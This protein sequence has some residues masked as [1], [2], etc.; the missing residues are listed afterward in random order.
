MSGINNKKEVFL[1][2]AKESDTSKWKFYEMPRL[3]DSEALEY[4]VQLKRGKKLHILKSTREKRRKGRVHKIETLCCCAANCNCKCVKCMCQQQKAAAGNAEI[5][6]ARKRVR[7]R[8]KS[9]NTNENSNLVAQLTKLVR[10]NRKRA[11]KKKQ[12]NEPTSGGESRETKPAETK[13]SEKGSAR[14][15]YN[16]GSQP[17]NPD[18]KHG[19]TVKDM[20]RANELRKQSRKGKRLYYTY[21]F[22]TSHDTGKPKRVTRR[23]KAKKRI[24][25]PIMSPPSIPS[26]SAIT[27]LAKIRRLRK[28]ARNKK[29]NHN[30]PKKP[31][32]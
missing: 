14:S 8:R 3:Q 27:A 2:M 25:Q 24:L 18:P 19:S 13:S 10:A 21:C 16:S 15:G 11:M 29:L 5:I 7:T 31:P 26:G 1:V 6:R 17:N 20:I 9:R 32:Q 12:E 23:H 4:G 28:Q 30:P 22:H